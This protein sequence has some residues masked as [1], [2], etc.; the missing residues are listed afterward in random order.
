MHVLT[1]PLPL[2]SSAKMPLCRACV[3]APHILSLCPIHNAYSDRSPPYPLQIRGDSGGKKT[4]TTT[5][6]SQHSMVPLRA[7]VLALVLATALAQN[8]P[9]STAGKQSVLTEAL[10][11]LGLLAQNRHEDTGKATAHVNPSSRRHCTCLFSCSCSVQ[12]T[13]RKRQVSLCFPPL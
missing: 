2:P 1:A 10:N 6:G 7:I 3:P 13:S 4:N 9:S 5:S 12:K 8:A 11:R